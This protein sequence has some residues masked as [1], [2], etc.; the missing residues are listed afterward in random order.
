MTEVIV[1][2]RTNRASELY[3]SLFLFCLLAA[4]V[5]LRA[6]TAATPAATTTPAAAMPPKNTA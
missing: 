1:L 2:N 6:Q 5:P 4:A 3:S